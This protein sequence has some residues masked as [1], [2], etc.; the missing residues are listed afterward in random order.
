MARRKL[1]LAFEPIVAAV[2]QP[3]DDEL[4][5]DVLDAAAD[6]LR[7]FGLGRWSVDDVADAAGVGRTSV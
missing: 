7:R 1:T 6:H 5:V 4:A 2:G 3:I